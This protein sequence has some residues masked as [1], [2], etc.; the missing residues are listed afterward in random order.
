MRKPPTP[1]HYNATNVPD[2]VRARIEYLRES[3]QTYLGIR[4]ALKESGIMMSISGIF[5]VA[6]DVP[7]PDTRALVRKAVR[8]GMT[9]KG[10]AAQFGISLT[11]AQRYAVGI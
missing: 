7:F 6:K 4:D 8:D 9:R 1:T 5:Q 3:G 10:A 2:T 11:T